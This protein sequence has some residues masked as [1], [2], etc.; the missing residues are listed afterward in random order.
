MTS[1]CPRALSENRSRL[2]RWT[3]I[4]SRLAVG[5]S[6]TA[7]GAAQAR[8]VERPSMPAF[9]LEASRPA[10]RVEGESEGITPVAIDRKAQEDLEPTRWRDAPGGAPTAH[11][12]AS[13]RA[14]G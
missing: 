5:K 4:A 6:A 11:R 13:L 9:R 7:C 14:H 3:A 2:F 12:R 10:W 8:A 1:F